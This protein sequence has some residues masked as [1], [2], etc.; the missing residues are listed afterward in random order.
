[1]STV[2]I[3]PSYINNQQIDMSITVNG[4]QKE[5]Q[6]QLRIRTGHYSCSL[7]SSHRKCENMKYELNRCGQWRFIPL[8]WS[9][10]QF[11]GMFVFLCV[12]FGTWND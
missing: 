7:S 9:K 8:L 3:Y 4:F 10:C 5:W 11:I 2:L 6:Q 12:R 1:M